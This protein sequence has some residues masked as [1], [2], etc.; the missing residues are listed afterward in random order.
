M[1]WLRLTIGLFVAAQT[2]LLGMAV[3]LSPP[4]DAGTRKLI[5]GGMLAATLVILAL[6]GGPMIGDAVSSL[7]RR[8]ISMELLFLAGIAAAMGISLQSMRLGA[9][10]VYF[11]VVS[12]LLTVYS[13]GRSIS[14]H[15]RQRALNAVASMRNIAPTARVMAPSAGTPGE[16]WGEGSAS[17][18]EQPRDVDEPSPCPLP[19]YRARDNVPV[20]TVRA[21]DVVRVNPG[22]L[23]PIDGVIIDGK[24]FVRQTPFT[25]ELI[26]RA[27]KPGDAVA[28]GA[29]VEDGSLLIRATVDGHQRKLDRLIDLVEQAAANPPALQRQADRFVQWFLPV[30]M[31]IA[32]G[33]FAYWTRHASL[34]R[35]LYAGL[36]VL[37]VACPCAAGLATPLTLWVTLSRLAKLGVIATSGDAI[38]RL[39]SVE[40][41]VFDKTGTLADEPHTSAAREWAPRPPPRGERAGGR[42]ETPTDETRSSTESFSRKNA[43]QTAPT[44]D[45]RFPP[46]LTSP[47]RG[48]GQE[49]ILAMIVTVERGSAHPVAKALAGLSG[50]TTSFHLIRIRTLPARGVEG[51]VLDRDTQQTHNVR[52][53]RDTADQHTLRIRVSVDDV[54]TLLIDL[55]ESLRTSAASAIEQLHSRGLPVHIMTGDATPGPATALAPS[56]TGMTPEDKWNALQQFRRPLFIG[57]GVNDAPALAGAHASI[58]ITGGSTLAVATA[59]ATLH[60]GDLT[61]IPRAIELARQAVRTIRSNLRWAVAYNLIGVL[62][63]ASGYLHP[64]LAAVLMGVSSAVVSFRAFKEAKELTPSPGTPGEGGDKGSA[65]SE[66]HRQDQAEPSPCPLPEYR[67]IAHLRSRTGIPACHGTTYSSARTARE[68]PRPVTGRNACPT[69]IPQRNTPKAR[70]LQASARYAAEYRERVLLACWMLQGV[71]LIPILA[72]SPLQSIGLLIAFL[73]VAYI[74][75]PIY[76]TAPDWLDMTFSMVA[77]GGVGMNLGWWADLGFRSAGPGAMGC[78]QS[79]GGLLGAPWMYVGMVALGTPAMYLLRRSAV[80]FSIRSWCC[81]GPIVLGIPGMVVGMWIGS[82]ASRMFALGWSWQFAGVIDFAWMTAGMVVGMLL[83]HAIGREPLTLA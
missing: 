48:E 30:V 76:A 64:I 52:L 41:V 51:L 26:S 63:A 62:L 32:I 50:D 49:R 6:L 33:G 31:A 53:E 22:E 60:G 28:S 83:P 74:V 56:R 4:E 40:S 54:P 45:E 34:E 21:G 61:A 72:L 43:L 75:K 2:M 7:K 8:R 19:A 57:D 36:A 17:I 9:G 38:E 16:G 24:S 37:L 81:V 42:G 13:A 1:P 23:I 59:S 71:L 58:A 77:V 65:S 68:V 73:F 39:A 78:C 55:T 70:E 44:V 5:D 25:G 35:G 14:Q 20:A 3:N 27:M 11:D 15:S 18:D 82:I 66:S 47:R 67:N 69:A 79:A 46:H 80:R 12:V 10:P 29:G